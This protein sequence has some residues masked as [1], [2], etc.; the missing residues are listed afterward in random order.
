MFVFVSV[1]AVAR[2][3]ETP[4]VVSWILFKVPLAD[5]KPHIKKGVVAL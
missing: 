3:G 5:S 4:H 1:S 2:G